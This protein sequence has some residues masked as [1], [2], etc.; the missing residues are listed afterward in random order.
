VHGRIGAVTAQARDYS[1]EQ[2]ADTA[3]KVIMTADERSKL[4]AV[5]TGAQVNPPAVSALEKM[6]GS[7]TTV[8]SF[9][10]KD[11]ADMIMAL[12]GHV[13]VDGGTATTVFNTIID[14]GQASA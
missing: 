14:G 11:V 5:E 2:I 10:P 7:L 3:L 8:R 12:A 9:S 1:A 13:G 6:Q 4:A